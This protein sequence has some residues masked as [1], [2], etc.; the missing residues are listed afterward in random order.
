MRKIAL[1]SVI[2]SLTLS[3]CSEK[4]IDIV[5]TEIN[6]LESSLISVNEFLPQTETQYL[7]T[8]QSNSEVE[9]KSETSG[10]IISLDVKKGQQVIKDQLIAEIEHQALSAQALQAES[11]LQS[12]Q[13]TLQKMQNGA[14]IEEIQ[15]LESKLNAAG[16]RYSE[17]KKGA[18]EEQVEILKSQISAAEENYQKLKNGIRKEE[19]DLL[20]TRLKNTRILME[21]SQ[22]SLENTGKQNKEGLDTLLEDADDSLDIAINSVGIVLNQYLQD[23]IYPIEYPSNQTCQLSIQSINQQEITLECQQSVTSYKLLLDLS[24]RIKTLKSAEQVLETLNK[25]LEEIYKIENFVDKLGEIV[26][27]AV[28]TLNGIEL[29]DAQKQIYKTS[30]SN[31]QNTI[32]TA[33]VSIIDYV[34]QLGAKIIANNSALIASESMVHQNQAATDALEKEITLKKA[35]ATKEDL[36]IAQSQ[37]DQLKQQLKIAQNGATQEQL[38]NAANDIDQLKLQIKMSKEGARAEDIEM[39]QALITQAQAN[40]NTAE[41]NLN[42]AFIK[43]PFAGTISALPVTVGQL[44]SP[45]LPIASIVQ[46]NKLEIKTY[47][48]E[49]EKPL[50]SDQKIITIK[51]KNARGEIIYISPVIDKTTKKIEVIIQVNEGTSN[52]IIGET[53]YLLLKNEK[54]NIIQ[55]PITALLIKEDKSYVCTLDENNNNK[56]IEIKTGKIYGQYIEIL[57]G[58]KKEDKILP[59]CNEQEI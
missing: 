24:K 50:F 20:E 58:L 21:D 55:I 42:K 48:S 54:I 36:A 5:K 18:R 15:I 35:G 8:V 43:S 59:T 13:I 41:S 23:I 44:V 57:E 14:R 12:A 46:K 53:V 11:S 16:Q 25:A 6:D 30:I 37:I 22:K 51:D 34:Q 27:A 19:L 49:K 47:I 52:L 45:G 40:L 28:S 39:Q 33:I 38:A 29:T 1:L 4:P 3:S 7:G 26:N 56:T 9:I 2:I 17:L 31:S 10:K 32:D